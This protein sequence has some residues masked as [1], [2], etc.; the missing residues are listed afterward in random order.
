MRTPLLKIMFTA[1]LFLT[2]LGAS[3]AYSQKIKIKKTRGLSAVIESSVP[4]EEGQ[5]YDLAVEPLSQ[6]IDYKASGFKSRQNLVSFGGSLL[7]LKGDDYSRNFVSL[8]G[9]YG[10]NF[11]NLEVGGV[12]QLASDN[13]G[14]GATT[15]YVG[16]GFFSYNLV[17]NRDTKSLVYGLVALPISSRRG[18][19]TG[20]KPESIVARTA[21]KPSRY[22]VA[23]DAQRSPS[24]WWSR[25]RLAAVAATSR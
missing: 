2:F 23:K 16:G 24:P 19:C 6:N 10:W 5:V 21:S 12:L 15:D 7:S 20:G 22:A 8:Q 25:S 9:R 17:A 13:L 14:A 1:I 4:L 18:P 11:T 3:E